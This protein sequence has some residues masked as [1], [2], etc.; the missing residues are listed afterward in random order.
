MFQAFRYSISRSAVNCIA[1]LF[2]LTGTMCA[3]ASQTESF[4]SESCLQSLSSSGTVALHDFDSS[5]GT[6]E[7]VDLTLTLNSCSTTIEVYNTTNSP[8]DFTNAS[9][10]LNGSLSGPDGTRVNT[11]LDVVD[12][13]G[14]A[15]AGMNT[16]TTNKMSFSTSEELNS[17]AFSLWE[18][19]SGGKV[20]LDYT[21]GNASYSGTDTGDSNLL[22]GGKLGGS[23]KFTVE[24]VYTTDTTRAVPEP[25]RKYL[26]LLAAAGMV[27]LISRRKKK[28]VTEPALPTAILA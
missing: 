11:T 4:S 5:L 24:Y 15:N 19:Q 9:L 6:L 27:F 25:S 14:T 10:T 3:A 17:S 23:A 21:K 7:G 20:L 12:P 18:N 13:S 16:F 2:L 22:F 26:A 8:V 28:S 1:S